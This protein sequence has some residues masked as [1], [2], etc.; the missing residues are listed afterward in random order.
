MQWLNQEGPESTI[1]G[2][3]EG[4]PRILGRVRTL[5]DHAVHER[6][7]VGTDAGRTPIE[8]LLAGRVVVAMLHASLL[9]STVSVGLSIE[10][11]SFSIVLALVTG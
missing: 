8:R 3:L 2:L 7:E 6:T 4:F 5:Q 9:Y 11:T 10:F 1:L